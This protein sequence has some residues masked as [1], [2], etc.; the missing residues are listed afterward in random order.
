MREPLKAGDRVAVYGCF[1]GMAPKRKTGTVLYVSDRGD[2]LEVDTHD[3]VKK[4]GV[5]PKQV[6]RLKKRE[7][8]RV[9]IAACPLDP[10]LTFISISTCAVPGYLEFIEVKKK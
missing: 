1:G 8:R 2:Y 6:R 3:D 5:H 7:R 4:R 9:W 10:V